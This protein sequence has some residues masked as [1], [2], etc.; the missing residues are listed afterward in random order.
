MTIVWPPILISAVIVSLLIGCDGHRARDVSGVDVG[1]AYSRARC[2]RMIACGSH[3]DVDACAEEELLAAC[4][5][6]P[7]FCW[8][9]H[10]IDV[11]T[12]GDCMASMEVMDCRL[13]GPG[14]APEECERL[15]LVRRYENGLAVIVALQH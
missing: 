15:G 8:A 10:R 11:E 12:W 6:D 7:T 14:T 13:L 1:I 4:E 2:S 9:T 5:R 3:G